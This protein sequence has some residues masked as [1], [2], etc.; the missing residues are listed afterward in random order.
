MFFCLQK[1]QIKREGTRNRSMNTK[2]GKRRCSSLFLSTV[3]LRNFFLIPFTLASPVCQA[4][5]VSPGNYSSPS[6]YQL[7]RSRSA[8]KVSDVYCT[9]IF[10]KL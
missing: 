5:C 8:I 9:L 6:R 10:L 2:W 1:N 7:R 4:C 3:R